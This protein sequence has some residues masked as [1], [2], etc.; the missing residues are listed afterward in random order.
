MT[1]NRHYELLFSLRNSCNVP[2]CI[3]SAIMHLMNHDIV[4]LTVK[5]FTNSLLSYY[6]DFEIAKLIEIIIFMINFHS[7]FYFSSYYTVIPSKLCSVYNW[8]L[9][10]VNNLWHKYHVMLIIISWMK[11][12]IEKCLLQKLYGRLWWID[13]IIN[14]SY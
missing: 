10:F 7:N 4:L 12:C 6:D 13:L 5:G 9:C 14:S 8:L 3:L 11:A 1:Q 2:N